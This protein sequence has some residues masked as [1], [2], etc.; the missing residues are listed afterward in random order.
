MP[1]VKRRSTSSR[2]LLNKGTV[3]GN[4][5]QREAGSGIERLLPVPMIS[6]MNVG[7]GL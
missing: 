3:N 4:R 6:L 1:T 2:S 5:G 7:K